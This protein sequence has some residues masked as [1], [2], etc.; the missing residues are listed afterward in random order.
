MIRKATRAL[1]LTRRERAHALRALGWLLVAAA[2]L[3]LLKYSTVRAA[4]TR[5]PSRSV[6]H[7]PM[8]AVECERALERAS[9]VLP[10]ARCLAQAIAA[11]CLLRR[12]GRD[13]TLSIGVRFGRDQ[14]FHA[15][16]WLEADSVIITGTGHAE[17]RVLLRDVLRAASVPQRS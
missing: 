1:A 2:A 5:V 6:V 9:R 11:A 8:T 17:H 16:A 12:D 10:R 7:E 15:H 13:S 4:F 3:R 14:R